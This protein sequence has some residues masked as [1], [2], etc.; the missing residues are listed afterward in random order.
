MIDRIEKSPKASN[1]TKFE[2]NLEIVNPSF[3]ALVDRNSKPAKTRSEPVNARTTSEIAC[4]A[5]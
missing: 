2:K 3:E 1:L 5:V 4:A